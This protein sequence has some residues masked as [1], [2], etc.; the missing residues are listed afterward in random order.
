MEPSAAVASFGYHDVTD[1]PL[2]SGLQR[3][4]ALPFKLTGELFGRH[5]AAIAAGPCVPE[6]IDEI[7]LGQP[8]RHVL[9]TFDDGGKSALRAGEELARRG[10]K[11][12]FF[13][14]TNRVGQ[15]PFL[16]AAEIRHLRTCGHVIGSHSH[17]HPNFFRELAPAQMV[18]EWRVSRDWLAQLL[19]EPCVAASVPGGDISA[20]VLRSAGE[21]GMRYLFTSEPTVTPGRV[22]GCWILGRFVP[23]CS[24]PPRRVRQL[25]Q[26]RGWGSAMLLRRLKVGARV[27]LPALY[28][29][30]V[31]NRTAPDAAMSHRDAARSP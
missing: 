22:A 18:E 10:W 4:G 17:T 9:L 5:L 27:L 25:A 2:S 16:T 7:D 31:R 29:R 8:G 26:L 11:G 28:R 15:R 19:G 3:P 1:D 13:V 6:L 21:A 20:L 14:I 23:K 24:T 12:H 30:Y